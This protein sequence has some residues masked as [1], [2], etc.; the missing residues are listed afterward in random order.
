MNAIRYNYAPS[1]F[2]NMFP[3]NLDRNL[4]YEMRNEHELQL[5]FVRI[6]WFRKFPLYSLPAESNKLGIE[7]Q[8]QSNKCTFSI[9]LR[10]Y[11]F[12]LFAVESLESQD[13]PIII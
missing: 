1:A 6:A 8:H 11:L 13:E 7:I 5:P 4:N 12:S 10:E 2:R 9:V 3:A